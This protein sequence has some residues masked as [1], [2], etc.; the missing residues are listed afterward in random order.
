MAIAVFYS[1][2]AIAQPNDWDIPTTEALIS[3]NKQNYSDH[4]AAR[5]NQVVS[6]GTVSLW[7]STTNKFNQLT[8]SIDQRLTSLYIITAD[9]VL[10]Y[11]I[12]TT[13]SDM[14]SVEEESVQI[15]FKYPFTVPILINGEQKIFQTAS[16]LIEYIS[17]L[18]VNYGTISKMKVSDRN[19]IFQE[20]T[21]DLNIMSTESNSLYLFMQ[22]VQL[23][24]QFKNTQPFQMINKDKQ[25]VND[26]LN[27][28]KK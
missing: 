14:A 12:Y 28:L 6:Q 11:N 2:Y 10:V 24:D 1:Q 13:L 20:V 5:N 22:R 16:N 23:S 17:L 15:S 4:Q 9:A 27:N 25:L 21:D 19:L 3:H 7:K 26:I 18:V 8:N